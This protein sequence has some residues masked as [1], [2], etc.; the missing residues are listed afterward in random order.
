MECLVIGYGSIGTRHAGILEGMGHSV[1]V[2]SK[3]KLKEFPCYQSIKEAL[4]EKKVNY[5]IISNETFKHYSSFME[6][7]ELGYTGKL[8]IEKPVFLETYSILESDDRNVFVAYNL[9]FHPALQKLRKLLQNEQIISICAYAG[10]YLPDWRPGGDYSKSYS[11]SQAKGGGVLRDLSHELDYLL[12]MLD[13]WERVTAIGGHFSTLDIVSDD[14]FALA[15]VTP[16][17]PVVT[18]QLNYLD[19]LARRFIVVNT[20]SHTI[21]VDL[22]KGSITVDHELESFVIKKNTTYQLMHKSI[23]EGDDETVCSL[24]DGIEVVRLIEAAENSNEK[25]EWIER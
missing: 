15:I 14:I 20:A 11:A 21:K 5:A 25:I 3:R 18:V 13:G 9:R 8:L 2:V 6:L 7:C 10:Q 1:N 16:R 24:A 22:I 12:W 4:L 19:R 23:L 17:C